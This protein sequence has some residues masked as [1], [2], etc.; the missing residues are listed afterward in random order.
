M[1]NE[2]PCDV[3]RNTVFGGV[4]QAEG[5]FQGLSYGDY[6]REWFV[7]LHSDSPFFRGY[8]GEICYLHGNVSYYYERDT[9][10]RKQA[11]PFQNSGRDVKTNVFRGTVI[12]TTTPIFVPVMAAFYSV[13]ERDP[14][15]G[16]TLQSIADCQFVCRRDILEGGGIWCTL[17]K[18]GAVDGNGKPCVPIDLSTS[19]FYYESPSF[20]L[21]VTENSPLREHFE[22]PI[23]PGSYDSFAAVRAV[24]LNTSNVDYIPDGVYRMRYGG[25]GRGSYKNDTIQDFIVQPDPGWLAGGPTGPINPPGRVQNPPDHTGEVGN[26]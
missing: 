25:Y 26:L 7:W 3:L 20:N 6:V 24:M 16:G 23:Q 18:K 5:I 13:G 2:D 9:G 19:V 11:E 4:L 22:I 12:W 10:V 8:R 21:T 17:E 15:H 14:Y 1:A